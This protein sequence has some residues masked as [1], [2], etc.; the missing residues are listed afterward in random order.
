MLT[1]T[2]MQSTAFRIGRSYQMPDS[3]QDRPPQL[4]Q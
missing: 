3:P 4:P 2:M 1:G